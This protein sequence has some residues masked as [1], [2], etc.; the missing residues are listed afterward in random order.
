MRV[1]VV[2]PKNKRQGLDGGKNSKFDPQLIADN[3][4]PDCL[5][6]IFNNGAVE[7]R[8]GSS[9]FNSTSVGSYVGDGLYTRHDRSGAESMCAWFNGTMYVNNGNVTFVTASSAQSIFT[10]GVRVCASEYENY[11]F[12]GNGGTLPY[13]YA[14]G[15]FTRHG[16]YPPTITHTAASTAVGVLSGDYRYKITNVN[17]NLVESDVGPV[18]VTLTVLTGQILITSIPTAPLSWGVS[19]RK[20]YRTVTSGSTYSLL[21]TLNNN[22]ATTHTDNTADGSLGALAPTDQGV[23]PLYS[24]I[25]THQNRLFCNDTA[26]PQFVWFSELDNPYIFKATNFV[27]VGDDAGDLV[28]GFEIHDNG[29]VVFCDRSAYMIYMPDQDETNWVVVKMRSSYGS[30]SP[31]GFFTYNNKIMFPAVQGGRIVGFAA[32]SGDATEPD[33]TLL[34]VT[35]SGSDLKSNRIEPDVFDIQNGFVGNISS[36]VF[37][38]KAYISVSSGDSQLTN[39]RVIIFDFSIGNLNKKQEASWAPWSGVNAAQFTIFNNNLYYISSV[40]DGFV[41]RAAIDDVHVDVSSAINSYFWTKEFSGNPGDESFTKDFRYVTILYEKSGLY[42]MNLTY[43]VD[44]DS[45]D[46]TTIPVDLD[47][48][49]SRWGTMVWGV[50]NW[51]A[52]VEAAETKI[53][54]GQLRG[55]RI[56]FK[57]SNQNTANQKFKIKGLQFVYNNKGTR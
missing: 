13:K 8:G 47:P 36:I 45:G 33:A 57:F 4:S 52:G 12:F 9:K 32:L 15:D 2:Y 31:F 11:I 38:N 40:S 50:D 34:T 20:I 56:Q 26:N 16:I 30:K 48:G 41:Y 54:L 5:N 14:N 7:T 42:S 35:A 27:R 46:G 19:A 10:A 43:R 6:V 25:I 37:K 55:K 49:G 21:A 3:E 53:S 29:L 24:A 39:N 23:P 28:R 51:S 44:S 17:T 22:T 1:D 18:S